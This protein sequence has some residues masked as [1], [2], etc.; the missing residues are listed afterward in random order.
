MIDFEW[1]EGWEKLFEQC[2]KAC[3]SDLAKKIGLSVTNKKKS[4]L[5]EQT[6]SALVSDPKLLKK[7]LSEN[8]IGF[9]KK[10]RELANKKTTKTTDEFPYDSEMIIGLAEKGIIDVQNGSTWLTEFIRIQIPVE[11]KGVRL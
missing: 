6:G 3:L 10:V 5:A 7:V 2:S 8:E 1:F 9:I 4:E 11:L